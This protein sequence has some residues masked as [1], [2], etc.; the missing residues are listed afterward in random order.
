ML[1]FYVGVQPILASLILQ[2]HRRKR[3][4]SENLVPLTRHLPPRQTQP[5][6]QWAPSYTNVVLAPHIRP[7]LQLRGRV[8]VPLQRLLRAA[9]PPLQVTMI[10]LRPLLSLRIVIH[11]QRPALQLHWLRLVIR[12]AVP[13][14][15]LLC[16]HT[17]DPRP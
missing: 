16:R 5:L 2:L 3:H 7:M 6:C 13:S 11:C 1:N 14:D 12:R 15:L 10:V 8:L 9:P 4:L 17:A